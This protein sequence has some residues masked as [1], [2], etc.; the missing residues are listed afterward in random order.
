MN[1]ENEKQF[2]SIADR[3]KRLRGIALEA[4]EECKGKN[5][6]M[7]EFEKVLEIMKCEAWKNS[8]L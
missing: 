4:L 7:L 2:E 5:L 1:H 8:V 6:T 3:A